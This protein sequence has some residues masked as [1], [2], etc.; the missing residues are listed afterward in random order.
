[1]EKQRRPL[2]ENN[3]DKGRETKELLKQLK[4]Q[5]SLLLRKFSDMEDTIAGN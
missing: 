2:K 4:T 1:M 5:N 3:G